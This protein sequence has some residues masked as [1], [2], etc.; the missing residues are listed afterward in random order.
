MRYLL[1]VFFILTISC[2]DKPTYLES[3][4]V[5]ALQ[6]YKIRYFKDIRTGLCFAERGFN[7]ANSFTCVPCD[8]VKQFLK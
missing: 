2:N 7:E 8:S 6:Q 3:V 5:E 4:N 1:I